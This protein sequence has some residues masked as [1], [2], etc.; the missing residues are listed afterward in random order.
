MEARALDFG[1]GFRRRKARVIA[2]HRQLAVFIGG[3]VVVGFV[4]VVWECSW[5]ANLYPLN[6]YVPRH[7]QEGEYRYRSVIEGL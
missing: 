1:P 3:N 7:F 5:M 6:P 2:K 4:Q